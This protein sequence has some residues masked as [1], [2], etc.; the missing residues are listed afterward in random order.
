M[1]SNSR[2]MSGWTRVT[3]RWISN[4]M[5][6]VEDF[7]DVLKP[8]GHVGV[9]QGHQQMDQLQYAQCRGSNVL[10]PTSHVAVDQL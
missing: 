6:R 10:K 2:V 7:A 3:Y 1:F 9:D 5:L 4:N 8:T